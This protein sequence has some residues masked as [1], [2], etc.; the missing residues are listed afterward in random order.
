M[1]NLIAKRINL[2]ALVFVT[3]LGVILYLW[4]IKLPIF[5]HFVLWVQQNLLLYFLFLLSMKILGILWPPLP[6]GLFTLGSIPAIGWE[7]AY[8]ADLVGNIIGSSGA[9][10][11]GKKYGSRLLKRFFDPSTIEKIQNV[12]IKKG[13]EF[14]AVVILKIIYS[15]FGEVVSYGAGMLGISYSKFIIG[16]FLVWQ[17]NI[18]IFFMASKALEGKLLIINVILI[19]FAVLLF[20]KIKGRYFE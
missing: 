11:I 18:P 5:Q 9:F 13:K 1:K 6:G 4:F 7:L 17:I 8:I 12:K 15:S 19:V 3:I 16:S 20:Y 2:I 10:F 14:E